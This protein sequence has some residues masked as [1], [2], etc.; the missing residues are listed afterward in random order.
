ME[1]IGMERIGIKI[2]IDKDRQKD[3]KDIKGRKIQR[4]IRREEDRQ[5]Y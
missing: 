5:K 3:R 1:R 2:A 4:E